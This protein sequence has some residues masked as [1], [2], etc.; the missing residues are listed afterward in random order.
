MSKSITFAEWLDA[1]DHFSIEEQESFINILRRRITDYRR[2]EISQFVKDAR[3]EF[4]KEE[5]EV[6]TANDLM[7]EI[8]S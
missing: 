2:M 5:V 4:K 6:K 1:A 3:D 8:M 7:E